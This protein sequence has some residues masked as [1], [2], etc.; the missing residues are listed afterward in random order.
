M[1]NQ[2]KLRQAEP[3]LRACLSLGGNIG[4]VAETFRSALRRLSDHPEIELQSWSGLYESAPMGKVAGAVFSNAAAVLETTLAPLPLLD[5][6]QSIEA[7]H[8]R[9][10]EAHWGPRTLDLDLILFGEQTIAESQL[11]V[12]HP[13][14]W[15][16]RFVLEP[17]VEIAPEARHP[18]LNTT[19]EELLVRLKTHDITI[20]LASLDSEICS[21][22][23][24]RKAEADSS[25]VRF[26]RLETATPETAI[27]IDFALDDPSAALPIHI[28]ASGSDPK[29][30]ILD[31]LSAARGKVRRA[32]A[33]DL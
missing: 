29:Q 33:I 32:A 31:V 23:W 21:D 25:G 19:V 5:V 9:T 16:R 7:E 1:A 24:I 27:V 6:L 15:Y 10:R 18:L 12:P 8:D 3:D 28:A 11:I 17:L 26:C 20:G 2:P 14:C 22:D 30:R 4:D 13:G